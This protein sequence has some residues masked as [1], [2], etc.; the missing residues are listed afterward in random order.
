MVFIFW[1]ESESDSSDESDSSIDS[2]YESKSNSS[3]KE[4]Q[5]IKL[6]EVSEEIKAKVKPP[7][8]KVYYLL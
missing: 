5:K 4:T 1:S 6:E 7:P 8:K 3:P 2:D